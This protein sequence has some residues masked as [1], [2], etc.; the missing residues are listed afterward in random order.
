MVVGGLS[1]RLRGN[2]LAVGTGE[3]G[4]GGMP[5]VC[6]TQAGNRVLSDC[7]IAGNSIQKTPRFLHLCEKNPGRTRR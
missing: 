2:Y 1:L 5:S 6:H 3:S 7:V 4:Q